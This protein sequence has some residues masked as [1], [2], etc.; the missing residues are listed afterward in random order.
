MAKTMAAQVRFRRLEGSD[1][2][3]YDLLRDQ[4]NGW[5]TQLTQVQKTGTQASLCIADQSGV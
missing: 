1:E 4:D 5:Q 2:H 3:S